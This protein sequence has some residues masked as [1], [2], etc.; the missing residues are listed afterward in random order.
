[1]IIGVDGKDLNAPMPAPMAL[2]IT[3]SD[4]VVILTA[5]EHLVS[6]IT[7]FEDAE[8]APL[9]VRDE[10]IRALANIH[11]FLDKDIGVKH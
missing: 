5:L 10:A 4:L 11:A 9:A 1:M 8:G 6:E 7:Q 2:N 3:A